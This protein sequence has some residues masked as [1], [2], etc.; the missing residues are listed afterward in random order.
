MVWL[1]GRKGG[2]FGDYK[3]TEQYSDLNVLNTKN[4]PVTQMIT[5]SKGRYVFTCVGHVVMLSFYDNVNVPSVT[6]TGQLVLSDIPFIPNS[7]YITPLGGTG[8]YIFGRIFAN[9]SSG[10]T[11]LLYRDGAL[12][13]KNTQDNTQGVRDVSGTAMYLI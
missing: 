10:M 6:S 11:F 7:D 2:Y 3:G 9:N 4:T 1:Q 5:T 13:V 12:Y 8:Y